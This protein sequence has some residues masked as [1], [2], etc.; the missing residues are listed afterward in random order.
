[1][2]A[3]VTVR[4][5]RND[6]FGLWGTMRTR[7]WPDCGPEDNAAD[8]AGFRSG[9]SALRVVF[10]AFD[11]NTPIG[12]AEISERNVADGADYKPSAYVEGWFVE[13]DWRGKG[14]GGSLIAAAAD[15]ARSEGFT[16]L[17]SDA[18]IENVAS[19]NAH[20]ALGFEEVSRAV[21]FAMRLD[22]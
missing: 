10:L 8:L 13:A 4:A 1:M 5:M 3:N 22:K 9:E 15:W 14:V 11:G 7:L 2:S 12:F 18:E 20:K 21:T 19:Q 16:H 17:C 6:E